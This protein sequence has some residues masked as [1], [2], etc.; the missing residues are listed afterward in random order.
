MNNGG[1]RFLQLNKFVI[2]GLNSSVR[3]TKYTDTLYLLEF[4]ESIGFELPNVSY[5]TI[6]MINVSLQHGWQTLVI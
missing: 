5:V 4:T 2:W 3:V 1:L 6:K